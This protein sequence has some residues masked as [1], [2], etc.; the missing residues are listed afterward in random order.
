MVYP[1]SEDTKNKFIREHKLT[2]N[3]AEYINIITTLVNEAYNT[4][5]E[6]GLKNHREKRAQQ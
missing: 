3:R 2:G 4:G 6:E 5:Y 1:I